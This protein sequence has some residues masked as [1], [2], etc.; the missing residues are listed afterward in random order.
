MRWLRG[1]RS[2]PLRCPLR[3]P[4]APRTSSRPTELGGKE[5][6]RGGRAG[7]RDREGLRRATGNGKGPSERGRGRHQHSRAPRRE[8]RHGRPRPIEQANRMR[9]VLSRALSVLAACLSVRRSDRLDSFTRVRCK[10]AVP[11]RPID[12]RPEEGLILELRYVDSTRRSGARAANRK[13]EEWRDGGRGASNK[14]CRIQRT[15]L[16]YY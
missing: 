15:V 8:G 16:Y 12:A 2:A 13:G 6:A 10:L 7:G 11:R 3:R 9:S 14:P 4:P 5:R 1:L